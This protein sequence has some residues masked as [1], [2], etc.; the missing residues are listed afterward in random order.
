MKLGSLWSVVWRVLAFFGIWGALLAPLIVPMGERL[1]GWQATSP[2]RARLYT[3]VGGLATILIASWIMTRWVDRR[4]FATLGLAPRRAPR[5]AA[6]GVLFGAAWLWLSLGL[7]WAGG[8]LVPQANVRMSATLLLATGVSTALNV[9]TQQLLLCGYVF[10]TLRRRAGFPLALLLSAALF[11]GYHAPAYRG[12]WLVAFNVFA[13]GALFCLAC[14][15]TE[16]LWLGS[17]IHFAWNY[18]VGP[19]LGLTMSGLA[20]LGSGWRVFTLRGPALF[21]GGD[22]GIEG[23]LIV[24]LTTA[25]G[26]TALVL[27]RRAA[28]A[29]GSRVDAPPPPAL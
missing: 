12:E 6:L 19:V 18:Q 11:A 13:A 28:R 10:Q 2:L 21:R 29:R 8:W 9:L 1:R 14:G 24:T 16:R 27:A 20:G 22:F 5:D 26:V 25:A 7:A 3:D 4:P 23:G 17:G 15:L